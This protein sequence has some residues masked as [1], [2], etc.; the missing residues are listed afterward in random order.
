MFQSEG[1]REREREREREE[2]N[3]CW[4]DV[5]RGFP[6]KSCQLFDIEFPAETFLTISPVSRSTTMSVRVFVILSVFRYKVMLPILP[7]YCLPLFCHL[8]FYMT[9]SLYVCISFF[10]LFYTYSVLLSESLST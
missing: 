6:D 1:E 4:A 2:R 10:Y 7:F 3:K 9:I 5:F 8:S